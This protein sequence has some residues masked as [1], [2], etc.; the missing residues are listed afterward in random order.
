M[1]EPIGRRADWTATR[2]TCLQRFVRGLNTLGTFALH[3]GAALALLF[4]RPTRTDAFIAVGF[5]LIGMFVVTAGYH[6]YFAHRSYKTTRV[7]QALLAFAGCLCTQK[8]VLWWASTHRQHHRFTDASGDP[9]SPHQRGFWHSHIFWTLSTDNEGYDPTNVRDLTR[10][11]ELCLIDRFCTVPLVAYIAL[12]GVVGGFHGVGWWYCVPTVALMH[13][14]MLI[15]SVS[16]MFG[17]RRFGTSDQSRNNMWLA[18]FTLGEGWHNNHHR[19]MASAR[20]GF[21][22]WEVDVT[23]YGLKALERFGLV[24]ALRQPPREVL[25]EGRAYPSS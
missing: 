3:A 21:Y 22:W 4:A 2:A 9:H 24:W 25:Q 10:Y 1:P 20:Q 18:F 19:Y 8:G 11:P 17:R 14:V 7:F 15:N 12:T 23:Y 13:A 5:Y 16:H 6:R